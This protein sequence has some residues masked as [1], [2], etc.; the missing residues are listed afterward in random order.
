MGRLWRQ[1]GA[2]LATKS[3]EIMKIYHTTTVRSTT[4]SLR[5][6]SKE[7]PTMLTLISE[8]ESRVRLNKKN[9]ITERNFC[10]SWVLNSLQAFATLPCLVHVAQVF[11]LLVTYR[12][13]AVNPPRNS[14][15]GKLQNVSCLGLYNTN[16][17]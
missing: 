1:C 8:F 2:Q 15:L 7:L 3:Y 16:R 14:L 17:E 12:L 4:P 6:L 5:V 10:G 13:A 11:R 9:R